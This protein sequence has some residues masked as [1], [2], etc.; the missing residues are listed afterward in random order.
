MR[1]NYSYKNSIYAINSEVYKLYGITEE[2]IKIVEG[3]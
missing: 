3:K 1:N 2:E